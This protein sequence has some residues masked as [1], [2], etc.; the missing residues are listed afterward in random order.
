MSPIPPPEMRLL[1]A[2]LADELLAVWD[3]KSARDG[4]ADVV[5]AARDHGVPVHSCV[6]SG[7]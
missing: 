2:D 3:G 6:A 1:V 4:T 7:S 5:N